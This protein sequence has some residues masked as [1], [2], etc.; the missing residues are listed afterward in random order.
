MSDGELILI[1][2]H[3]ELTK[4]GHGKNLEGAVTGL[5]QLREPLHRLKGSLFLY[6]VEEKVGGATSTEKLTEL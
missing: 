2:G 6:D 1:G 3:E 5:H 4:T